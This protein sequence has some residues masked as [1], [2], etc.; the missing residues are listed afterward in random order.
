MSACNNDETLR[1]AK[2]KRDKA[3]RAPLAA[4][5][6]ALREA[7]ESLRRQLDLTRDEVARLR[8]RD[9]LEWGGSLNRNQHQVGFSHDSVGARIQQ[10]IYHPPLTSSE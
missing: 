9:P 6:A 5:N 4:E 8:R 7:N 10:R 3:I 2:D 1:H